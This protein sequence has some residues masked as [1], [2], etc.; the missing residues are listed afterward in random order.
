MGYRADSTLQAATAR[1]TGPDKGC[2]L[3]AVFQQP[4]VTQV[5]T[6]YPIALARPESCKER[7][8]RTYLQF[9]IHARGVRIAS[10][11]GP[12]HV[13]ERQRNREEKSRSRR[14]QSKPANGRR[15]RK[16]SLAQQGLQDDDVP[17]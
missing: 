9:A 15:D 5:R 16:F 17:V 6:C 3:V 1:G 11:L 2:R 10:R 4:R 8:R 14:G 12:Q 13:A 7:C